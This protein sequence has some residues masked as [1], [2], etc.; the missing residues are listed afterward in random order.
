MPAKLTSIE[1]WVITVNCGFV[2]HVMDDVV[3]GDMRE[4][5]EG[6]R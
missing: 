4:E 6:E 2:V 1:C 3:I 5:S